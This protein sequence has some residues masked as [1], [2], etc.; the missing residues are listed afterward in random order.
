MTVRVRTMLGRISV[1]L[2]TLAAVGQ[3]QIQSSEALVRAMHDRYA[4]SWYRTITFTQKSTTYND[5]GTTKVETWYEAALLPGKLRIDV[6]PAADG[7]SYILADGNVTIFDK[8]KEVNSRPLVN[9]L[10]VLG[11]DVYRQ[12]PEKTLQVIGS[13]KYDV[14]KFHED[15]F[16]GRPMY[17]VGADKGDLQ[18]RQF[19][20]DQ[21]RLLFVRL[22]QPDRA[23]EKRIEDIRFTDYRP[24]AGA[25][26]A[27]RV[28]VRA[29]GKLVFSED[30]SDI[31]GN[32]SLDAALFD[33]KQFSAEKRP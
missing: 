26:V 6:G 3:A 15:T 1:V 28:E 32:P 31:K 8:G 23:D 7:R 10:L 25:W 14:S 21:E 13:E 12:A 19:W 5:D 33:P 29:E 2:L 24:L 4:K 30:Y 17:V 27:A 16:E 22:F 20:I 18:S 11:F 9:M